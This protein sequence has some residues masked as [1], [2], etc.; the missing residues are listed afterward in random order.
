VNFL[1]G[2][3][4]DGTFRVNSS[5][6]INAT[7]GGLECMTAAP[8]SNNSL[9]AST[10]FVATSFAPLNAPALT[11]VPTAPTAA[12]ATSTTQIATTAFV[13]PAFSATTNGYVKLACGII[14]QWGEGAF[15]SSGTT[16]TF[17]G[18]GGCI[19]FPTGVFTAIASPYGGAGNVSVTSVS[20]TQLTIV[21]SSNGDVTWF[22]I[23]Y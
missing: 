10:A 9:A 21:N 7:L 2:A 6:V 16:I 18:T 3:Y 5:G 1:A 15:S 13:N 12:S 14:I 19:A 20:T 4:L 17:V 11:G 22:A 23:G 8:G